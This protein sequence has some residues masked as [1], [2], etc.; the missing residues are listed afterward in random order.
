MRRLLLVGLV[1]LIAACAP[2]KTTEIR[3][4]DVCYR[5]RR[6][7][8]DPKLAGELVEESG[9]AFKFRTVHCMAQYIA[10]QGA[11]LDAQGTFFATD[12]PTGRL[13]QAD[14]ATYVLTT[15]NDM[16]NEVDF[17]AYANAEAAKAAAT[18]GATQ[19]HDWTYVLK[20]GQQERLTN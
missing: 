6:T 7:I 10:T 9:M 3:T 18:A 16:T 5:C 12:F 14:R 11:D 8:T 1:A 2:P 17:K 15:I 4:G 20:T 19:T 13:I